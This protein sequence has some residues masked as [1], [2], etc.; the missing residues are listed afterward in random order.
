MNLEKTKQVENKTQEV[1]NF[2]PPTKTHYASDKAREYYKNEWGKLFTELGF[3]PTRF[4]GLQLLDVGCGS[5]EK[6]T[7]YCEW[8]ANVTGIDA[9]N[10]V[11]KLAQDV[12]GTRN[13][14]LIQT[15]LF[16]FKPE[17]KFDLIISDGVLHCTANTFEALQTITQ[18]LKPEG[19]IIISLI[20]VRGSLWW[21]PIARFITRLLGGSDFHK[22]ANW[23]K[24]LFRWTRK[25]QEGTE[26]D[27]LF[28]R[29]EDSWA[30][31]WFAIPRWNQHSPAEIVK[32]LNRLGLEHVKSLPSITEM[33]NPKNSYARLFKKLLGG[34]RSLIGLY[35][36]I[37]YESNTMYF[38]A[39]KKS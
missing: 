30:Y 20:N 25:V 21:F 10:S 35:W 18:H 8:G 16:D 34:S 6:A 23:G 1:Y 7:F 15:S 11:L 22:R 36:L 38:H 3:T 14:K 26:Q 19:H 29:S 39:V 2:C 9:T 28:F 31:D 12:I 24:R 13:I 17:E 5:C 37:N 27:A 32:W 33:E 4:Q